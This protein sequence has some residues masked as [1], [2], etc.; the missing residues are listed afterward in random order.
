YVV[1]GVTI[2]SHG[3]AYTV[4]T[5]T[6]AIYKLEVKPDHTPGAIT[7]LVEA[8]ELV[9]LD[10]ITVGPG[11]T[12]YATQNFRNTFSSI[13]PTGAVTVLYSAAGDSTGGMLHFPAELVRDGRL[14]YIA[15][16]NF[17]VGANAAH[18]RKGTW[19]TKVTLP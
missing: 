9:G 17:P 16:L 19:I 12:L 11:D 1:N 5:G 14:F 10:G 15:D 8:R 3:N 13:S 7:K 18:F 2:D 6:G 4:N